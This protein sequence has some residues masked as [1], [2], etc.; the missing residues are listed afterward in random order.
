[1][2]EQTTAATAAMQATSERSLPG[3]DFYRS[4]A[5]ADAI[6]RVAHFPDEILPLLQMECIVAREVAKDYGCDSVVELG[7]Y[8]GRALELA[9]LAGLDYLGIDMDRCAIGV[10]DD[11]IG[12]ERLSGRAAGVVASALDIE[13]WIHAVPGARPLYLLP[14][15]LI[16]N[17]ADPSALLRT[18]ARRRGM[19]V[20]SVFNRSART[21]EIRR[22]YYS[23]C[24]VADLT[25]YDDGFGGV[26]F[27]GRSGFRSRSF[28]EAEITALAIDCAATTVR[29]DRNSVG[30][31]VSV[32][33]TGCR[34][35]P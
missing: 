9:R 33:L 10:L 4:T 7:C 11:R 13:S 1:M 12:R 26:T 16:G 34:D 23:R 3:Q 21:T 6:M 24:G 32:G 31:C 2:L 5:S 22:M 15:N 25:S 20:L 14:F 18:V 35:V 19:A 17:F 27:T 8:D 28:T 29:V 30:C